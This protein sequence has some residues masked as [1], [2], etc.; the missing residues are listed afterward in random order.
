MTT[1]ISLLYDLIK[2]Y[3][4]DTF[5]TSKL[6]PSVYFL[7]RQSS[8]VLDEG[9]GFLMGPGQNLQNQQSCY[10][11]WERDIGI[12]LTSRI[13]ALDFNDADFASVEKAIFERQMAIINKFETET[14]LNNSEITDCT[15]VGDPGLE[16][17]ETADEVGEFYV[18]T[19]IF[20]CRYLE[21]LEAT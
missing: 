20:R 8:Q 5:P 16:V 1:K 14:N 7:E 18:L 12:V 3:L 9:Y 2:D 6:I 13:T 19:T 17:L 15:V 11:G 4:E 10:I 21:H